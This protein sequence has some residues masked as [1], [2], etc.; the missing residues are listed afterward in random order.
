MIPREAT[1]TG[2]VRSFKPAVQD[3]VENRLRA[4][5]ES[6]ATGFGAKA[7]LSFRPG[8]SAT[9]N[10]EA[11]ALFGQQ[12]ASELVGDANVIGDLDPSMGAEDFSFM[13]QA[14]PGAYFR[15][16]QGAGSASCFLHNTRYDFNDEILPLGAALFVRLA[17][18][19]MPVRA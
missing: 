4:L 15:I 6:I 16:G 19:A 5:V 3:L 13:L 9:V 2:T 10:T 12:V 11:E 17:E 18:R 1:L 14:R 8:Y 7:T